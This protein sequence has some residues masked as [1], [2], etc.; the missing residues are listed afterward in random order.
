[1]SNDITNTYFIPIDKYWPHTSLKKIS[2]EANEEYQRDLQL[3]KNQRTN[4]EC[5]ASTNTSIMNTLCI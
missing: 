5:P 1:M 4:A 3:Y 2:F